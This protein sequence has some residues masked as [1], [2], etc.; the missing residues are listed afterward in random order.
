MNNLVIT[1]P[2]HAN[3]SFCTQIDQPIIVVE[4]N[5][6]DSE[7]KKLYTPQ[8]QPNNNNI[9]CT[10][11]DQL[12]IQVDNKTSVSANRLLYTPQL[13]PNE[14]VCIQSF[15]EEVKVIFL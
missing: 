15:M 6:S 14:F 1:T 8:L 3:H 9:F 12:I 11:T 13:Q 7:N 2:D 5:I 4:N 10:Q